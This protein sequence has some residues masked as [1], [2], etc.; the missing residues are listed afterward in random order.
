MSGFNLARID[1]LA[2]REGVS[3]S[4]ACRMAQRSSVAARKRKKRE[5]ARRL[6]VRAQWW[7][8]R[9]NE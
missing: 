4:E 5:E 6:T 8:R 7:W 9:D 3:F 2:R 1:V